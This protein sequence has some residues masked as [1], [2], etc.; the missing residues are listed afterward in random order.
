MCWTFKFTASLTAW[1]VAGR[2]FRGGGG[3]ALRLE[4]CKDQD[5]GTWVLLRLQLLVVELPEPSMV[6]AP[7]FRA[8][9]LR[10]L[11]AFGVSWVV[12]RR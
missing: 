4:G 1:R 3:V 7:R 2:Y 11:R 8:L 10:I 12:F 9:G 6:Y 5:F